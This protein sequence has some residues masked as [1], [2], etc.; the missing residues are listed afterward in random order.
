MII[1]SKTIH[2]WTFSA[3]LIALLSRRYD[4]FAESVQKWT[5]SVKIMDFCIKKN[6]DF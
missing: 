1:L 5:F 2:F 4:D 3:S 6:P